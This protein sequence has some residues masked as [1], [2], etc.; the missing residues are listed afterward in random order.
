MLTLAEAWLECDRE[1]CELIV[2]VGDRQLRLD[3]PRG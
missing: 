3:R 2:P 1:K